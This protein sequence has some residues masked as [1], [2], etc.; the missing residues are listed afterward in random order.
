MNGVRGL[1]FGFEKNGI[2]YLFFSC[3]IE[4]F[5]IDFLFLSVYRI[6]KFFVK[7]N[8]NNISPNLIILFPHL[9]K[10]EKLKWVRRQ[11]TLEQKILKLVTNLLM[12][13][14]G[15]VRERSKNYIELYVM[16]N[17]SMVIPYLTQTIGCQIDE[18]LKMEQK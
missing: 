17:L 2:D 3:I 11:E 14:V 7:N 16:S 8:A 4:I 12:P 9:L 10:H 18:I 13:R 1:W 5:F 15:I 6:K